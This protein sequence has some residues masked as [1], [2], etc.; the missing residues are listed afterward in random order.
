MRH[1]RVATRVFKKALIRVSSMGR[2][3]FRAKE[4]STMQPEP[5]SSSRTTGKVFHLEA[6]DK[7]ERIQD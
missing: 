1:E 2:S 4:V 3:S 7:R 6:H 5:V